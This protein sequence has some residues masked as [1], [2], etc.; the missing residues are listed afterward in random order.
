MRRRS[1]VLWRH[2][3]NRQCRCRYCS[4]AVHRYFLDIGARK[5]KKKREKRT[6]QG[7]LNLSS[8]EANGVQLSADCS[9]TVAAHLATEWAAL[10]ASE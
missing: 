8:P 1:R 4:F 10:G 3:Q 2:H 7:F 9:R 6:P 5:E